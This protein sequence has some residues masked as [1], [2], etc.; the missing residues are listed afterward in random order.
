MF[1]FL[2]VTLVFKNF[3]LIKT[4]ETLQKCIESLEFNSHLKKLF[5]PERQYLDDRL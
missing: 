4:Y 1:L 3:L 5:L 2:S